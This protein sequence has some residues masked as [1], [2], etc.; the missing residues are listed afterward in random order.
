MLLQTVCFSV[1]LLRGHVDLLL[2]HV[3]Q[4]GAALELLHQLGF[5]GHAILL[6][7][8]VVALLSGLNLL[9]IGLLS[10]RKLL[11]PVLIE[12]LVLADVGLLA[13][14]PLRLVHEK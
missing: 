8:L 1:V 12:L 14:L 9:L 6:Q 4:L 11:V 13:L 10:E 2:A 5:K 7:Q 3:Q